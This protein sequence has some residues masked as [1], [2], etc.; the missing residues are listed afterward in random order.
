VKLQGQVLGVAQ[1]MSDRITYTSDQMRLFEGIVAQMSA[2]A[3]NARLYQAAQREIGERRKTEES[4][5]ASEERFRALANAVPTVVWTAAP[6][7]TN[8]YASDQWYAY[9]GL[10]QAEN[11]TGWTEQVLHPDDRA[12][13]AA[14]WSEALGSGRDYEIEVRYRRFDG[15]YRWFL[16]RAVP[17]R[18]GAGRVTGWFGTTTDIEDRRQEEAEREQ[19]LAELE[20][21]RARLSELNLSLDQQVMEQTD[22]VR[23]LAMAL[24]QAEQQERAQLARELHDAAGQMLTALRLFLALIQEEIPAGNDELAQKIGEARQ[25]AEAA[26]EELR[27]VAHA[28]RPIGLDQLGLTAALGDLCRDFARQS[29]LRVEFH[30]D[31][32]PPLDDQ[33]SFVFYRFAQEALSNAARHSGAKHVTV[34]LALALGELALVIEDDGRG[35]DA[36]SHV[37]AGDQAGI[38]LRNQRER[39]VQ[40]GGQV[41]IE[42]AP[43]RGTRLVARCPLGVR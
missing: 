40:I 12:R 32:L 30:S 9:T 35:F 3:R 17:A 11:E 15:E 29:G 13:V 16:T 43:D 27:Q 31:E 36:E 14:A 39:L 37:A 7:G 4:L 38:G 24:T 10:T 22:Q 5:R 6:D 2:A 42:S 18:D 1:I 19:L 41:Q 20:R 25:L 28:M 33:V 34:D 8:T 26:H 23:K 21:E